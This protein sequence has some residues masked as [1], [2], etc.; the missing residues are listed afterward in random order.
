M[1]NNEVKELLSKLPEKHVLN[2]PL[3]SIVY[4]DISLLETPRHRKYPSQN[5]LGNCI[6]N[7]TEESANIELYRQQ[8]SGNVDLYTFKLSLIHEIGHVVFHFHLSTHLKREWYSIQV[9]NNIRWNSAC[10]DPL[11]QFC[12]TYSYYYLDTIMVEK[13]F[14][15]EHDFMTK[16]VFC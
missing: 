3:R 4:K 2:P 13:G 5:I 8:D 1:G 6:I 10:R 15:T 12:E 7:D 14:P 16:N 11:E 9:N